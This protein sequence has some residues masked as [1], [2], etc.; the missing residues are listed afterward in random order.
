MTDVLGPDKLEEAISHLADQ[1]AGGVPSPHPLAV[2]GIRSRGDLL[3]QRLM[4]TIKKR[5]VKVSNQGV[6]DI[7]LYRDDLDQVGGQARVRAT[8]ILFDISDCV[9]IL[10]DDV[11]F[12]G[13]TIRA[14]LDALID[15]GR[16]KA[17]KLAVLV[18]RGGRELPIQPDFV[19]LKLPLADQHVQVK[20]TETDG[21]DKIILRV[22][23]NKL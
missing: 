6:L 5:G 8:E 21:E 18:D 15:L 14:A 3:A 7:T 19:G 9:I 20:F 11:I 2:V 4:K 16:P 23:E 22:S 10:V 13:R 1:I 12:T 17:I